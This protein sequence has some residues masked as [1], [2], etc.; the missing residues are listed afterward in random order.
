MDLAPEGEAMTQRVFAMS[1][2][3]RMHGLD[4]W[5]SC[6][7]LSVPVRATVAF[8]VHVQLWMGP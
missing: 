8:P 5:T 1:T 3:E 4:A 7:L 6:G 2:L